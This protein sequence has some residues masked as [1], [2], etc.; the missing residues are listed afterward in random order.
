MLSRF[1]PRDSL[2]KRIGSICVFS[3]TNHRNFPVADAQVEVEMPHTR[4]PSVAVAGF[5]PKLSHHVARRKTKNGTTC[6]YLCQRNVPFALAVRSS[7]PPI[8]FRS[9]API[10]QPTPMRL[11]AC[12]HL[13]FSPPW[14]PFLSR[15]FFRPCSCSVPTKKVTHGKAQEEAGLANA[16]ISDEYKLEEVVVIPLPP[17][18][19]GRGGWGHR[20]LLCLL[21]VSYGLWFGSFLSRRLWGWCGRLV[22]IF[23]ATVFAYMYVGS[24]YKFPKNNAVIV[25]SS[26]G[27]ARTRTLVRTS[28][29]SKSKT[30]AHGNDGER[31]GHLLTNIYLILVQNSRRAK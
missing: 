21:F 8:S 25:P 10:M 5:P 23:L 19:L 12:S 6:I 9:F 4:P 17:G 20:C 2:P 24:S 11:P 26:R 14:C 28:A 16:G 29:Q 7:T 1:F 15:H 31:D 30:T 22:R 3:N 18:G 13:H 27:G